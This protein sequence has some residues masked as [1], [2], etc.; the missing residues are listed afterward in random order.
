MKIIFQ[1]DD[2][3]IL[4]EETLNDEETVVLLTDMIDI[5]EWMTNAIREKTRRK[6]D[7]IIE[8][9]GRGSRHTK[10]NAKLSII[11][12]LKQ[13]KDPL[14]KSA[15]EKEVKNGRCKNNRL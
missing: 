4:R 14:L 3:T 7:T 15:K 2:G 5:T 8:K 10:Q 9:S 13:E 1:E 6:M 12:K 11:A